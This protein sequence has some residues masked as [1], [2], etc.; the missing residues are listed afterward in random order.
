MCSVRCVTYVPDRS[1]WVVLWVENFLFDL[2]CNEAK[3]L[4]RASLDNIL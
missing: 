1:T 2:C 4:V 3:A